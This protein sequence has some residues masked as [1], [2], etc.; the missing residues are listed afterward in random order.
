MQKNNFSPQDWEKHSE[1][2]RKFFL[3]FIWVIIIMM[4][5]DGLFVVIE[6]LLLAIMFYVREIAKNTRKEKDKNNNN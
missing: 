6:F 3:I 4:R 5:T 1:E 2:L